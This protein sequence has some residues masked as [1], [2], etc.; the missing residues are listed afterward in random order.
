MT[1][2]YW[3]TDNPLDIPPQIIRAGA[4]GFVD[5]SGWLS[6]DPLGN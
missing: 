2:N 4:N 6:E 1:G 5:Y 3:G